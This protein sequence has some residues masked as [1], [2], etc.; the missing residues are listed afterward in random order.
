MAGLEV[1]LDLE[2][3][4][5]GRLLDPDV[6]DV[7]DGREVALDGL[8]L[9]AHEL[10]QL[11]A[12]DPHH[13]FVVSGRNPTSVG[14]GQESAPFLDAVREVGPQLHRRALVAVDHAT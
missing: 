10:G 13:D 2:V 3:G 8:G 14:V 11:L 6:G 1:D 5:N 7:V 4:P 9:L 12:V